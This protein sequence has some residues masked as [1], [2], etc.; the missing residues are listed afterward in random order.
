VA[1]LVVSFLRHADD[2]DGCSKEASS[3]G[4]DVAGCAQSRH[5]CDRRGFRCRQGL[6]AH[7]VG[8]PWH[9]QTS[10]SSQCVSRLRP[11]ILYESSFG[12]RTSLDPRRKPLDAPLSEL[13]AHI[14]EIILLHRHSREL[15]ALPVRKRWGTHP[16]SQ[17]VRVVRRREGD[18]SHCSAAQ[19]GMP[20][21][22]Q[23]VSRMY[24]YNCKASQRC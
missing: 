12:K 2:G 1:P 13:H 20:I 6:T 5:R 11:R 21:A 22:R 17:R 15:S 16:T 7:N 8:G 19:I 14:P 10:L 18:F 4:T 9:S 3:P 24:G 23:A